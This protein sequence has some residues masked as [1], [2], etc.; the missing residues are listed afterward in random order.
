MSQLQLVYSDK[1]DIPKGAIEYFVERDG[2]FHLD[3]EGLK[4]QDD[5]DNYAEALK[6]RFADEVA[7]AAKKAGNNGV[8][9]DDIMS[10]VKEA[11][12][13]I[14]KQAGKGDGGNGKGDGQ[15]G[16]VLARLHDL[17]R[18]VASLTETNKKLE[19][20]RDEAVEKGKST[21]IRNSLSE[22]AT[23]AGAKP[24][25]VPNLVTLVESNFEV[26]QDGSIVTKI[27]LNGVSPNMKPDDFFA[28]IS[29]DAAY[30]MFWGESKGAGADGDGPGGG[31]GG[32]AENPWTKAGWNM[33]KQGQIYQSDPAE[34]KRLMD[35]AGVKLGATQPVR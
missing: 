1:A 4:T 19:K 24:D 35:A 25:G 11:A 9:R 10:A 29:R 8:S 3:A 7:D 30:R 26:A 18:D 13:E 33:T 21:T 32:G 17:E 15:D 31:G 28:K 12:G 20:E 5:F 14:V 22:S 34:A 6:K 16:E 23:K 2:K 27:D